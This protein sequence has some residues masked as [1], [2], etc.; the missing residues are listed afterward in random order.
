[1]SEQMNAFRE[2]LVGILFFGALILVGVSTLVLGTFSLQ[3]RATLTIEFPSAGGLRQGDSVR[4]DGVIMGKVKALEVL[5]RIEVKKV[6]DDRGEER[7]V[8]VSVAAEIEIDKDIALQEDYF[9]Q[10]VQSGVLGGQV[11]QIVRG[12]S[13]EVQ[14]ESV[15]NTRLVGYVQEGALEA[16]SALVRDNEENLGTILENVK[17]VTQKVASGEGTLGKLIHDDTLYDFAT[18]IL[19]DI[20]S[21]ARDLRQGDGLITALVR[22][23][24]LRDN[25]VETTA[26]IRDLTRS[27]RDGQG[28]IGKLFAD[29]SLHDQVY[30][31]IT[32]VRS[33]LATLESGEGTIGMLLKNKD[34][35]ESIQNTI[36]VVGETVAELPKAESVL[37]RL[38][39]DRDMGEKLA[40][41][42]D[43]VSLMVHRVSLGQGTV[44]RL[45][46]REDIGE[47][48]AFL[49][50]VVTGAV[51][52][53]R[54]AAPISTF[55]NVIF[56]AF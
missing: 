43:D 21:F 54:E 41:V 23:R 36:V 1:M 37:G 24:D 13:P 6:R 42:V 56:S 48:L 12:T 39:Y 22:D 45:L 20:A 55:A 7:E 9:I 30:S 26:N 46:M 51:E 33:I 10:I 34:L 18:A 52:D 40:G 16:L 35:A 25:V 17:D 5:D 31:M 32:D 50:D 53:A 3:G 8:S 2:T 49:L 4:V 28:T 19:E 14:L 11:I 27:V 38:F 47:K 44:G 15:R 29:S